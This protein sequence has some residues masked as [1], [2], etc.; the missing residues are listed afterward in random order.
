MPGIAVMNT[1]IPFNEDLALSVDTVPANA[2]LVDDL[3]TPLL[4]DDGSYILVSD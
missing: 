2:L 3:D 4:D 1:V